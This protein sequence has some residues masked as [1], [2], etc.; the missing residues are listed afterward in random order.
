[1]YSRDTAVI[2]FQKGDNSYK[3][4]QQQYLPQ[5]KADFKKVSVKTNKGHKTNEAI[6]IPLMCLPIKKQPAKFAKQR[7]LHL[8]DLDL[9]IQ[10][11]PLVKT[12]CSNLFQD[13]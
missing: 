2:N 13:G 12:D 9:R 3:Y 4:F 11:Y 5:K 8:K 6:I 7:H 1:M 10:I